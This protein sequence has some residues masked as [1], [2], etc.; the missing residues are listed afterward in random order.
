MNEILI[1]SNPDNPQIVGMYRPEATAEDKA[2]QLPRPSGYK[3]LCAIPEVDKTYDSGLAKA[4][5][6]MHIEEVLTTVLFVVKLGPDC[7]INKDKF[8]TG[9]W[10][11]EGDFILV[12]PNT[13]SRLVIHGRE[14]RMIYDDSVDGV[15]D[16]P[17]GIRRK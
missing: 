6:T 7:Y 13:G 17:R 4:E 3:I 15:V 11:K 9:P 8:P 1:G 10:C 14:F 5:E 2:T 12:R 16:D